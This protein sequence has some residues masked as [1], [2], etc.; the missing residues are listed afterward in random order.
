MANLSDPRATVRMTQEDADLVSKL[1]V[2]LAD[3]WEPRT[4]TLTD[5]FRL[6]IRALA[7]KE[8]VLTNPARSKR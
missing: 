1:R 4:P 3:R 7:Q 6:A 8:R 5:I 2:K